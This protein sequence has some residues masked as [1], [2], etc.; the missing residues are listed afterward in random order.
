MLYISAFA[1]EG[2]QLPKREWPQWPQLHESHVMGQQRRSK[3]TCCTCPFQILASCMRPNGS[4]A[5]EMPHV[6][7]F[8]QTHIASGIVLRML[9]SAAKCSIC[10]EYAQSMYVVA[11]P[12]Q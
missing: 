6:N 9:G 4:N 12:L 2:A 10:P 11:Q 1:W 3:S 7:S 5:A 8:L